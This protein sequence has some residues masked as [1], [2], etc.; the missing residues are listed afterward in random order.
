MP[1]SNMRQPRWVP[2]ARGAFQGFMRRGILFAYRP[3]ELFTIPER[4]LSAELDE[5]GLPR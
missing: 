2:T 1:L 5:S 3:P 4:R